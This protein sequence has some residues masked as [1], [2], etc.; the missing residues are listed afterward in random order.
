MAT[1][2]A[3]IR[4]A[5]I[6]ILGCCLVAPGCTTLR[7]VYVGNVAA[8]ADLPAVSR[9]DWVIASLRSGGVQ[10]FRVTSVERDT[11]NGKNVAVP[12]S[13][14]SHLEVRKFSGGKTAALVG[15][16]VVAA[17]AAFAALLHYADKHDD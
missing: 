12:W 11:L 2:H 4:L 9:G 15:G 5:L 16:V 3:P 1:K 6:A 14:I 7:P 8:S 10:R 13:E 17:A